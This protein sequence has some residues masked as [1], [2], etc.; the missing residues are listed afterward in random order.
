MLSP[1]EGSFIIEDLVSALFIIP[2]TT[3][4]MKREKEEDENLV[5]THHRP[6]ESYQ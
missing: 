6:V 1:K 5:L 4:M 2:S 3:M